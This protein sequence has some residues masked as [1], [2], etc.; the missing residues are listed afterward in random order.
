MSVLIL[1]F[2]ITQEWGEDK[3]R[4]Y[5]RSVAW[6]DREI[7]RLDMKKPHHWPKIVGTKFESIL[8]YCHTYL[9]YISNKKNSKKILV[10]SG[11]VKLVC[12]WI[13]RY[14]NIMMNL[15]VQLWELGT[16]RLHQELSETILVNTLTDVREF[17]NGI[18]RIIL[19]I[20]S[21]ATPLIHVWCFYV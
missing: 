1:Q 2:N 19:Y 14:E 9:W 5:Y 3:T 18:L 15:D 21:C 6:C 8:V 4:R 12:S 13:C 11:S 10:K 17:K 7:Q 16:Q 20:S